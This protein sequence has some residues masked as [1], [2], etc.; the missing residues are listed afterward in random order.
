MIQCYN[1][2][3]WMTPNEIHACITS[4]HKPPVIYTMP[5]PVKVAHAADADVVAHVERLLDLAKTGKLTAL[6]TAAVLSDD[7]KP[8]GEVDHGWIVSTGAGWA[9]DRAV[10]RL[11]F[12]WDI[13]SHGTA[14]S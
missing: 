4:P 12:Y 9:L 2:G 13:F 8:E 7:L 1:C 5:Q 10:N 6:A 14:R 11:K 3:K